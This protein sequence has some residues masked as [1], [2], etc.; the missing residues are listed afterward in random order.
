MYRHDG[1]VYQ[2]TRSKNDKLYA[3]KLVVT[4][5]NGRAHRL[6]LEYAKSMIFSIHAEDRMTVA[7]VAE[8]GKITSYCYVCRH[9][10]KTQKSIA[11]GIGPVCA[12]K[13]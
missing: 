11:L 5:V 12:K 13:V 10:L 2:V 4:Y 3:K 8:L 1:A 6:N 9:R 7:E